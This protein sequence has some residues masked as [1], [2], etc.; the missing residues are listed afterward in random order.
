MLDN[1]FFVLPLVLIVGAVA[2]GLS[3]SA[4]DEW[5]GD[6]RR[7]VLGLS[8]LVMVVLGIALLTMELV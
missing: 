2:Y 3:P 5:R 7:L 4:V 6:R 8:G 1:L